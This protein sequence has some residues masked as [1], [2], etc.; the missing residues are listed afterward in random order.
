MQCQL[1][2][3]FKLPGKSVLLKPALS[4]TKLDDLCPRLGSH[5]KRCGNWK[6][7]IS[8]TLWT[9]AC[10]FS[11]GLLALMLDYTPRCHH[12]CLWNM[13][14]T[15]RKGQQASMGAAA[16]GGGERR[17]WGGGGGLVSLCGILDVHRPK[18]RGVHREKKREREKMV[19][20]LRAANGDCF[21]S[22]GPMLGLAAQF[23]A[24]Q[25]AQTAPGLRADK[26]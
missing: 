6:L 13:D 16:H 25:G 8:R 3:F 18:D 4:P 22:C 19:G 7:K 23:G 9:C 14:Q 17:G 12:C 20:G 21:Q 10:A 15:E 2:Y 26:I 11:P 24:S 5:C 1:L